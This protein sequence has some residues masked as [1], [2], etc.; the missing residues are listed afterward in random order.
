[1]HFQHANMRQS[2]IL[3]PL[4]ALARYLTFRMRPAATA[5]CLQRCLAQLSIDDTIVVGLG[6][7]LLR[8]LGATVP[9]M[10]SFPALSGIS[11][12]VPSTQRALWIW[13]RG[14]DRGA[15]VHAGRH[16][17][18]TLAEG[19]VGDTVVDGFQY[20]GG[21]DLSG[22]EDGTEN[23]QGDAAIAA[24]FDNDASFVAVQ[25]WVHW[26]DRFNAFDQRERDNIIGR[27]RSD[28]EELDEAPPSAHVKR[29]AQESFSPEAWVVRRSM[30]WA[31]G[32]EEGLM[33][34]AFGSSFDAFEAQLRR[35]LG[36]DDGIIDAL[37]RFTRPQTGGYF[38]CPPVS[39]SRLVLQLSGSGADP[40]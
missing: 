1:M 13:L 4:P 6:E 37:L 11:H 24:A 9:G 32:S 2:G 7:P 40:S 23:P 22:Y 28:N 34:V 21:R 35:M 29:T 12:E 25:R 18:H 3:Q 30:P 5:A 8:R 17:T 26:L 31:E 14:D 10:R 33:F 38:W 27:R 20:D 16:V 15:L 39:D 36:L 19:F